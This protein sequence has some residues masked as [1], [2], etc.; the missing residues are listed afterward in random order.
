[1]QK[2]DKLVLI[3]GGGHCR[4][5]LDTVIRSANFGEV[6][7]VDPSILAGT[8]ICGCRVAGDDMALPGLYAEG[9]RKAFITIGSIE[10]TDR[11]RDVF[12]RVGEIGFDFPAIIDSCAVIARS[13]SIAPG[14][15]VGKNVIVNA[16]AIVEKV[17]ILNTGAVIEHDCRI[18]EF[19]HIAVGAVVCGGSA[20]GRDA[21][22]GAG[23]TVIQEVR[24]GMKSVV[25]AGAVVTKDIPD[26][27]TAVGTP[28]RIIKDRRIQ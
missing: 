26:N 27:C 1:M 14:V 19:A 24:I 13:A 7:I 4:S 21:F 2:K 8:V 20:V 3:G 9:F 17:A 16:G 18:G 23:A 15:F 6:V 5:V 28:A 12:Q 25:G 10:S 11:R 22:V